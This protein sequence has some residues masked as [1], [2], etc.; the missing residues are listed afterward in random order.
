MTENTQ[1]K[2]T[3]KRRRTKQLESCIDKQPE[4]QL[5]TSYPMG[6]INADWK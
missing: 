3:E 5:C 6:A 1:K 2:A 4:M